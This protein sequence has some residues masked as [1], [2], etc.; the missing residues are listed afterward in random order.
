MYLGYLVAG[1][2]TMLVAHAA[3]GCQHRIDCQLYTSQVHGTM[4]QGVSSFRSTP[5]IGHTCPG[6]TQAVKGLCTCS[7]GAELCTAPMQALKDEETEVTPAAEPEAAAAA[8]TRSGIEQADSAGTLTAPQ[9]PPAE[10]TSLD[11]PSSPPLDDSAAAATAAAHIT[12]KALQASTLHSLL[13]TCP[14]SCR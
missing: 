9:G 2:I 1:H 12:R 3:H 5:C 6:Q 8:R 10:P 4:L 13:T 11:A 7:G 14:N